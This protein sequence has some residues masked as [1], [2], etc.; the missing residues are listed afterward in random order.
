M[1]E[2]RYAIRVNTHEEARE[3]RDK[4][5]HP[6]FDNYKWWW[7]WLYLHMLSWYTTITYEEAKNLWLLGETNQ[8]TPSEESKID[9]VEEIMKEIEDFY[10]EDDRIIEIW[11]FQLKCLLQKHLSK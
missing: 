10:N 9:I 5:L 2:I 4:W 1:S 8:E 3:C 6:F 7:Y 11:K